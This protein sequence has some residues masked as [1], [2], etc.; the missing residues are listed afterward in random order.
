MKAGDNAAA[1]LNS[2]VIRVSHGLLRF[3]YRVLGSP[4]SVENLAMHAIGLSGPAGS[5]LTRCSWS[6]PK[7][8]MTD[9]QWHEASFEFD[10]SGRNVEYCLIAPRINEATR[11]TGDGEW[12]LDDVQVYAVRVGPQVILS[13]VW[14]DK[15]LA[16]TGESILFSAW[17]ENNGDEDSGVISLNLSTPDG[18]R[19]TDN[20]RTIKGLPAGSWERLD[21]QLSAEKPGQPNVQVITKWGPADSLA[22]E[23]GSRRLLVIDRDSTYSRQELCTDASGDWRLL[24][25]PATLQ[26]GNT[27]PLVAAPHKRSSEI[28]RS[29]YGIC[30]QLPR[31][32]DYEDPFNA[33]H[34]IDDDPN[35]CWSSQQNASPFPGRPP[36]AQIDLG[37]TTTI[38]QVNLV[39]YWRNTAFPVGFR[40]CVSLDASQWETTLRVRKHNLARTGE[41]RGDKDVQ[42]FPLDKPVEARACLA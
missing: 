35:T 37:R 5:E 39:P 33:V 3:Q 29:P 32:R 20:E 26:A 36:W 22:S 38:K 21:W 34:L 7:D 42:C 17:L 13:H 28:K 31:S 18:V 12:L 24:E 23:A 15:P 10:F 8:R 2:S 41:V 1:G 6:P 27:A 14:T 4:R 40:F 11:S 30:V 16:R 9:G 19:I 25:R